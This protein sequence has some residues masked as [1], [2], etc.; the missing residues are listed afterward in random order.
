MCDGA[1]VLNKHRKR[2]LHALYRHTHKATNAEACVP[3][4]PPNAGACGPL[5]PL[6]HQISF[7]TILNIK[8]T[9]MK[10]TALHILN[11]NLMVHQALEKSSETKE[12]V[13]SIMSRLNG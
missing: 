6:P 4:D 9:E 12:G 8:N 2:I 10:Q 3:L 1:N 7:K 5:D 11:W 13:N